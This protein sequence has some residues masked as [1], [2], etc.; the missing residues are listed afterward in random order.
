MS[1]RMWPA[2]PTLP[3]P[4]IALAEPDFVDAEYEEMDTDDEEYLKPQFITRPDGIYYLERG[5]GGTRVPVWVC[6]P[7]KILAHTRN[8]DGQEWGYYIEVLDAEGQ[9]HTWAM[10]A[11][12]LANGGCNFCSQLM[13]LGLKVGGS[14]GKHL[15]S[16]Y[17]N[18]AE[19]YEYALS[20]DR[21]GWHGPHFI[22]FDEV[23]GDQTGEKIVPQGL[24]SENPF[25]QSG[26]LK[27]WQENV[28]R[29]CVGNSR[30]LLAVSAA[31]AAP[32]LEPL[33]EESG[34][35]HL[36]GESAIGKTTALRLG[37]STCGGGPDGYIKP[38]RVTDNALELI[39]VTHNDTLLCLD[40]M[41]QADARVVA[42]V[43]YMLANDQGKGRAR[44][45]GQSR[46]TPTW[47]SLFLSTGEVTLAEK[48]AEDG[49]GRVKAGQLVRVVDIPAD[50]GA[51]LG[52]FE[53][54]HGHESAGH[55]ARKL[56]EASASYYG[57]PLRA[58]LQKFV[59]DRDD[60]IKL[61][62]EIMDRFEVANRPDGADGQVNRVCGRFAIVA[63]AGELGI[64]LGVLPWPVGEASKAAATCFN[65]WLVQRGGIGAAEIA[66]GVEQVRHFFQAHG[67][68]R[69]QDLDAKK[70]QPVGKLAGYRRL[71]D[72]KPEFLVF[73][74]VFRKEICAGLNVDMVCRELKRSGILLPEGDQ[75]TRNTRIQGKQRR[76]I[77]LTHAILGSSASNIEENTEEIVLP[78]V[79]ATG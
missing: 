75:Y 46:K 67:A 76:M 4:F 11:R 33:N 14:K 5:R 30:L 50:A 16:L 61:A 42:K 26:N 24:L 36:V 51:G 59:T 35:L 39:A 13:A 53:K 40:E 21:I 8:F 6:S 79:G 63:A 23:Y 3:V 18:S 43:A 64:M 69:I 25:R 60:L 9:A 29:Y 70:P 38:W 68:T 7:L 22:M 47:R 77:V 57:T 10:S 71:K 17:L 41:G 45:D 49:R 20:V 19:V 65:A 72:G 54:L 31:M 12:L 55:F 74:A 15:L 52:L 48:I 58:F 44:G 34:G 28:G 1:G 73:P 62:R 27:E 66:A 32:L 56:K 2:V 37:G 78:D